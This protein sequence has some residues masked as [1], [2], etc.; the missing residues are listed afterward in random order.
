M[1]D[2]W[3]KVRSEKLS[4]EGWV[5]A[6][7]I[8]YDKGKYYDF[9]ESVKN[10]RTQAFFTKALYEKIQ[11]YKSRLK[12]V[13]SLQDFA[14][15][16]QLGDNIKKELEQVLNQ[17]LSQ[18]GNQ[19]EYELPDWFWVNGE[20]PGYVLQKTHRETQ[21]GLLRDFKFW[22]EMAALSPETDDDK[23][24]ALYLQI[25]TLDGT[26]SEFPDF[27]LL[28][29]ENT[30]A[31]TLGKGQHL[32]LLKEAEIL[33]KANSPFG[34][35]LTAV[36]KLLLD[37]VLRSKFYWESSAN[38]TEELEAILKAN[39]SILDST[40]KEALTLRIK[41]FKSGNSKA[42]VNIKDTGL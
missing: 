13:K 3:V 42:L 19:Q 15:C 14:T 38:I 32:L 16:W 24:V 33:F 21:F 9:N 36:K 35:D 10:A 30:L 5:F 22:K 40:D 18:A 23:I 39:F 25:Y 11:D 4:K 31:S 7:Q 8:G 37:D 27:L 17:K 1:E 12:K 34:Q 29:K 41:D 28:L 2:V 20:I 26:E 6:G